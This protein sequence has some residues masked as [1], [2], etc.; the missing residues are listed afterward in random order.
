MDQRLEEDCTK[1]NQEDHQEEEAIHQEEDHHREDHLIH[2]ALS[3]EPMETVFQVQ[4]HY[5]MPKLTNSLTMTNRKYK[6][7]DRLRVMVSS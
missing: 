1:D 6:D 7:T 4:V 2:N 5:Q 3:A